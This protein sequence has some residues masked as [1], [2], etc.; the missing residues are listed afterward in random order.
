MNSIKI[1]CGRVYI[2][3][4]KLSHIIWNKHNPDNLMRSGYVIHH[5]DKNKLNDD[6]S[7]L[8]LML[9]GE[10]TKIHW[11]GKKHSEETKKKI[12]KNSVGNR[13]QKFS[14]EHKKKISMANIGKKRSE[15]AKKKMSESHKGKPSGRKGKISPMKGKHHSE[16]TKKKIKES[17]KKRWAE[18]KQ[19]GNN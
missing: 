3:G 1:Y 16:E 12:S 10:H 13:G 15:E 8:E 18:R 6:I 19:H 14:E 2:N 11:T 17:N 7:N 4:K 5:K 9:N